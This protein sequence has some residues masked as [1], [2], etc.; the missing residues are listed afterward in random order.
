MVNKMVNNKILRLSLLAVCCASAAETVPPGSG[1]TVHEWGTFTS[2]ADAKGNA[3]MWLPLAAPS[4]LPC[5][6]HRLNRG[7]T[8]A[9]LGS[10][11]R[12]E[13]PVLY[14]YAAH[15]LT[16][17]VKV[18]FPQ[19]I[20]TEW[21]PQADTKDGV[22]WKQI[23]LSAA[24]GPVPYESNPSHYYAARET[25]AMT[26]DT[27][28][29]QDRM[30][31]YRGVGYFEPPLGP[32]VDGAGHVQVGDPQAIVFENRGGNDA[33]AEVARRKLYSALVD[34]GLYPKEAHAMLE[35]WRDSWFEEGLRVFCIVPRWFVDAQLPL[36]ISPRPENLV[37]TFVGR[38]ELLAP[39]MRD[40]IAD[41]L[42][43]GDTQTLARR[44]R[45]LRPFLD[46]MGDLPRNPAVAAW[47]KEKQDE[48]ARQF[49]KSGC[50]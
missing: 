17:N 47:L 12:M 2:V 22:E 24:R 25:D 32:T 9:V 50:D 8:K 26:V 16:A 4:D 43:N 15:S 7:D 35:T 1:L 48:G 23:A 21:Y 20:V 44:G 41:A 28:G 39:W 40:E 13:T 11:V 29:E 31:F 33:N 30:I 42:R 5:F 18:R 19:G 49:L 36:S 45:F 38:I 3:Q 37:R 46:Q 6:V 34:S 10:L 27:A 14:F